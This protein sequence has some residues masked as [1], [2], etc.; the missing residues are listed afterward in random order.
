MLFKANRLLALAVMLPLLGQ[1]CAVNQQAQVEAEA[2]TPAAAIDA[3]VEAEL[4]AANGV[5][6]EERAGDSDADLVE[7]DKAELNSYAE[8]EYELP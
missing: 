2:K 1:G 7:S 6:G 4:N 5:N 8:V 3:A